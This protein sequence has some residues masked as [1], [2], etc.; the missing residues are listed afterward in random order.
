MKTTP[1]CVLVM[2]GGTGGHVYPGLA[3][4]S[5]L[6][7]RGCRVEWLGTKA[8]LESR[9]V[10]SAG[11]DLHCITVVGLRG[12]G[13]AGWLLA[14]PRLA[15]ALFQSLSVLR[16]SRPD[17]VLGMGGFASGPGGVAAW[18]TR[19]P[20]LVHEQN[21]I[22]GLTNRVLVNLARRVYEA[23]PNTFPART[24]A[25]TAGNPVRAD[26]FD[27]TPRPDVQGRSLCVLVLGGS[28]GASALNSYLPRALAALPQ[29]VAVDVRHQCGERHV[30][31]AKAA[32]RDHGLHVDP[33]PFIE[34][35]SAAYQ[36]ADLVVC[37]A[38]AMTVSEIAAAGRAALFI[39]FPHAVDDH[40][41]ANASYL[42]AAGAAVVIAQSQVE[43]GQLDNQLAE[44]LNDPKRLSEMGLRAR[45]LASPGAA[46]MVAAGCLEMVDV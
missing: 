38:G 33:E 14:V 4:A 19:K 27:V 40:Q 32:Y 17:A 13:I 20:L 23:F 29:S 24:V 6:R 12:R 8:G 15:R 45:Q 1:P 9:V 34:D 44:L 11:I 21:A 28:Q 39:P 7:E 37:R 2:A 26:I 35:M 42:V 41:T 25:V 10:P 36:W 43:E 22:P 3:V 18:L 5:E 16:R 30:A 31:T 46:V